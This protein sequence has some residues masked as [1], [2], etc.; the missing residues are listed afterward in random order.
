M[1][2]ETLSPHELNQFAYCPHQWYYEKI[3]GKAELRRLR[4]AYLDSLGISY[5]PEKSNFVRGA[6]FHEENY[7]RLRRRAVIWKICI[8]FLVIVLICSYLVMHYV[9]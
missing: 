5:H 1:S 6:Q 2:K 9:V 3:Y 7:R 4:K 8:V